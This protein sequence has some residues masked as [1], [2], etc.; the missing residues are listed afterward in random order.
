LIFVPPAQSL[1]TSRL[2][3]LFGVVLFSR[4]TKIRV[5]PT[6]LTYCAIILT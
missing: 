4:G 2:P 3:K 6:V 5:F 1:R